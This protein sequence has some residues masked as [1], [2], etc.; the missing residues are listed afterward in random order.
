MTSA[1]IAGLISAL[2]LLALLIV[3]AVGAAR[4][5]GVAVPTNGVTAGGPIDNPGGIAALSELDERSRLQ[6]WPG[7]GLQ[8]S[9]PPAARTFPPPGRQLMETWQ[10]NKAA[11]ADILQEP[12]FRSGLATIPGNVTQVLEQPQGRTW[13]EFRNSA[14]FYGGAIY[15]FGL[16]LLIAIFLAWRGRIRIAEGESGETVRR[17]NVVERANH[18]LTATSF[19]LLAITGLIILYGLSV[20]RPWLGADPYDDVAGFSAW[21]HVAL[22][23]PFVL[24]VLVMIFL[25]TRE[26]LLDRLDW[27]WMKQFGGFLSES[28]EKPPARRFNAG[29]KLVF[30]SVVLSGIVLLVTGLF[31]MFPFDWAGYTGMQVAQVV[32]AVVALLM[33]GVIIGHIYIG[34]IGMQGAF[35]AMWSGRVDRNWAKEHHQLWYD[36]IESGA[37]KEAAQ[38]APRSRLSPAAGLATGAVAAV[39][40]ALVMSAVYSEIGVGSAVATTRDN[41]A[42][43]LGQVDLNASSRAFMERTR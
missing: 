9:E 3:V 43:H 32:H 35:E 23:V 15:I 27:N 22:A 39:V 36:R 41:P 4:N 17:F 12:R 26:N 21:S 10:A 7:S 8:K 34:T 40:L 11:N 29:Q 5:G 16:S 2:V 1:R 42:V 13:R 19:L 28:A 24:G 33:V 30:W 18:W 25:W 6:A 20:I 37:D 14:V 38:A 31:L